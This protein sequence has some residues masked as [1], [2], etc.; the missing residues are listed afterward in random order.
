MVAG[1][2]F[3]PEETKAEIDNMNLVLMEML[4][5]SKPLSGEEI[6]QQL[7][8]SR[9]A[10]WKQIKRIRE[11]GFSIQSVHGRG[12]SLTACP[13]DTIIPEILEGLVPGRINKYY[14][15]AVMDST[16]TRAKQIAVGKKNGYFLVSTDQQTGG[17]GRLDRD[18]VSH[19]GR[20]LTFTLGLS[21]NDDIRH[22]FRYTI[23]TALAVQQTL[24][25]YH[26]GFLI[27]WPNDVL[28][29][30][31]KICGILSEMITEGSLVR[32]VLVGV[33]ININSQPAVEN[34]VSLYQITGQERDVNTVLGSILQKVFAYLDE[35]QSG[36]Y[37]RVFEAWK[38]EL[39][40]I[41][42]EIRVVQG[43]QSISGVLEDVNPD[44]SLT[45]R[46]GTQYQQIYSGDILSVRTV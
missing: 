45:I 30:D 40:W 33:G 8:I 43:T 13:E 24:Q 25:E 35:Y 4:R 34:A 46:S 14:H 3:F 39:A 7:G 32:Q 26:P 42:K 41:G 2:P 18:W 44:G 5:Q 15:E 6:G 16:N 11:R 1:H 28:W 17:R 19:P 36:N 29:Q 37:I 38:R 20:D 9:A 12:Y 27:K 31:R 10:V 23:L 21:V 22:F